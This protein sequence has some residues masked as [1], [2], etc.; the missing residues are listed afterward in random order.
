MAV[1]ARLDVLLG[2]K[3]GGFDAGAK[4]GKSSLQGLAA[5]AIALNSTIGIV[6]EAGRAVGAVF[7]S[8]EKESANIDNIG[9]LSDRLGFTTED[10]SALHHG[11]SLAGVASETL[12]NALQKM[13]VNLAKAMQGEKVAEA[14]QAM[15]LDA[16]KLID[17][18]PM[19]AL[20]QIANGLNGLHTPAER[21]KAAVEI[22]GKSGAPLLTM[23]KDGSAGLAEMRKEADQ[24]GLTFD[25]LAATQVEMAND[26][27]T[28]VKASI[29][30]LK[31]SFMIELAPAIQA[32]GGVWKHFLSEMR[33]GNILFAYT[34]AIRY[35]A[36]DLNNQKFDG[37]PLAKKGG[38][39][40]AKAEPVDEIKNAYDA[41]KKTAKKDQEDRDTLFAQGISPA[42]EYAKKLDEVAKAFVKLHQANLLNLI[43][44]QKYAQQK[45][46][47]EATAQRIHAAE[48][49]RRKELT[50]KDNEK[51]K[52]IRD[53]TL[54][55]GQKL[56]KAMRDIQAGVS[57]RQ[58]NPQQ[59]SIARLQAKKSYLEALPERA[60]LGARAGVALKGSAEA[61]SASLGQRPVEKIQADIKKIDQ[62][63]LVVMKQI[64]QKTGTVVK[65]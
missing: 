28:R 31:Q 11:A 17:I 6:K 25:K 19:D 22:F 32:T 29:T 36:N 55:P 26:A 5:S 16:K 44:D 64:E 30:G 15:G 53:A 52:S 13:N 50:D 33:Q 63:I 54:T 3:T 51:F 59:A 45:A 14:F 23:L 62:Q 60:Q 56:A 4:K 1:I 39:A 7:D 27:M 41:L 42:A 58:L 43:D 8:F 10:L 57:A 48:F 37:T 47:L 2:M 61:F 24:L 9:K 21:A 35:A 46:G 12:N 40:P 18:N 38:D 65:L 34:N 49:K 20:G